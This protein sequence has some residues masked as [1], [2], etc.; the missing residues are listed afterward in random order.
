LRDELG[1]IV[2][3][4]SLTHDVTERKKADEKLNTSYEQIRS[5]SE[6]L[7]NVREEERKHIAREISFS[8]L[9]PHFF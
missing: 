9:G 1:N 2:T 5:L 3:I 8:P 7:T 4:L 6:H